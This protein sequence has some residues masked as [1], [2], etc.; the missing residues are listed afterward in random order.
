MIK[1]AASVPGDR[2]GRLTLVSEAHIGKGR[3]RH[4]NV[5]CDCGQTRTVSQRALRSGNTKSCGCLQRE[6]ASATSLRLRPKGKLYRGDTRLCPRCNTEF[7]I[8][9][10]TSGRAHDGALRAYCRPCT[11]DYSREWTKNNVARHMVE[12]ARNRAV[13]RGVPFKLNET[14]IAIPSMCPVYGVPLAL[15][16]D[17]PRTVYTATLDRLVPELGYVRGNVRVISWA[18]NMDKRDLTLEKIDR[19]A[20]YLRRELGVKP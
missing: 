13:G 19:I 20:T 15:P 4:W 6:K 10:F 3:D 18:A 14:D 9:E 2:F 5:V 8:T 17:G 16:G 1:A 11:R 7:P 12:G